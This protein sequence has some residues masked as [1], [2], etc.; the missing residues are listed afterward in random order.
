[1]AEQ[2]GVPFVPAWRRFAPLVKPDAGLIAAG[3]LCGVLAGAG[4]LF[5]PQAI[6]IVLDGQQ[7]SRGFAALVIAVLCVE[8]FG[9]FGER[10]FFNSAAQRSV[11][12]LRCAVFEHLLRQEVTW[13]DDQRSGDLTS[14]LMTDAQALENVL[15]NEL[16]T[17]I[18]ALMVALGGSAV[19]LWI[20]PLLTV[21]TVLALIPLTLLLTAL[22]RRTTTTTR[23]YY[24]RLGELAGLAAEH[25]AGIR[26]VRAF[27]QE[28][29]VARRFE[30]QSSRCVEAARAA[31]RT[32]GAVRAFGSVGGEV[33]AVLVILVAMPSVTKGALTTGTIAAFVVTGML[34]LEAFRDL[35]AC[36]TELRRARGGL[37]RV[38]EILDRSP[39]VPL[40]GGERHDPVLGG[41]AFE[42]VRFHYPS[43][44]D[45]PALDGVD[46]AIAPGELVALVGASGA[47]KSTLAGLLLRFYDPVAG[48]VTV[49][50]RD[51][52]T[53]DGSWLRRRI[54]FV[55]QEPLL[56]STTVAD[57]IRFGREEASD[58]E[59]VAAARAANAHEF[60]ATLPE[61]YATRV[62]ERGV[63]LSGGQRQRIAI[64]R[65]VLK[66]PRI[67]VLDEAT[68]A[69]DSESEFLVQQ[70]IER[71]M[72]G[73]T[74]LV[75]AHRLSTVRRAARVALLAQGRLLEA[76]THESLLA[77]GG[78]YAQ[79]VERQILVD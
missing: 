32:Y 2:A 37:E 58:D 53:L 75:I 31:N 41:V 10:L 67:L 48:R 52:R 24:E 54:G 30:R 18:R 73:R 17:G 69:L 4:R 36:A 70:A 44:P 9:R 22:D 15:V 16:S 42:G 49:D 78:F 72:E 63:C 79:L 51:T 56:F 3:L 14:R 46:L 38:V 29:S 76:G 77:A 57:N 13:F 7:L 35:A 20:S 43:R 47:G 21:V 27:A 68:S 45:V 19:L 23:N 26:T 28:D 64:A 66:D 11:G 60:V 74:T 55:S 25:T 71:L 59:V 6:R 65:A 34:A 50:G 62:G 40:A 12:R 39:R 61:G 8:G 5:F 33:V 1:M